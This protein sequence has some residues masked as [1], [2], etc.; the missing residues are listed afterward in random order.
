MIDLDTIE[1][2]LIK[3]Q[4]KAIKRDEVPV[5]AIIVYNDKIISKK[6]N[7]TE[8]KQNFMNHA[9]ILVIKEAMRKLKNWRLD[10]CSLYVSLEPCDMCKEIIKKSRIKNVYYFSKQNE[11]ETEKYPEYSYI[12]NKIISKNMSDFFKIKR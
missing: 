2:E 12:E 11:H 5:S 10:D 1:K 3:L 7:L 6:H 8:K 9:E 4:N